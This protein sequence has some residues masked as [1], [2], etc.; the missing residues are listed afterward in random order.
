MR[1]KLKWCGTF[2][3]DVIT[4]I[5][6]QIKIINNPETL[7]F[8]E[9]RK[10]IKDTLKGIHVQRTDDARGYGASNKI[11]MDIRLDLRS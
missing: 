5:I 2:I 6:Q 3:K 1:Q 8:D 4:A 9:K 7:S 10:L 11:E